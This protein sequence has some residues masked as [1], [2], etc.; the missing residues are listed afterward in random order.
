MRVQSLDGEQ[1]IWGGIHIYRVYALVIENHAVDVEQ[2]MFKGYCKSEYAASGKELLVEGTEDYCRGYLQA[3]TNTNNSGTVYFM[4]YPD[5]ILFTRANLP[6]VLT[7][8]I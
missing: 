7:G 3:L 6:L 8:T 4:E 2:K 1:M 5:F